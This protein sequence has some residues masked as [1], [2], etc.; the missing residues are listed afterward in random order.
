[1]IPEWEAIFNEMILLLEQWAYES[2]GKN[3]ARLLV[4]SRL[5]RKLHMEIKKEVY[6][7]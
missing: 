7:R 4:I 1:M 3:R 6:K 2:R 5:A